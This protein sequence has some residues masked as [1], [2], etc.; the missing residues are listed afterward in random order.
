[1]S[2]I[3]PGLSVVRIISVRDSESRERVAL[4]LSGWMRDKTVDELRGYLSHLPIVI[5]RQASPELADR[6]QRELSALGAAVEL[7]PVAAAPAPAGPPNLAPPPIPTSSPRTWSDSLFPTQPPAGPGI[8]WDR[9]Q[10]IGVGFF[11]AWWDNLYQSLR[12]PNEF[13]ARMPVRGGYWEPLLYAVAT[14]LVGVLVSLLWQVPFQLL[15][16]AAS[17]GLMGKLGISIGV[18]AIAFFAF[19]ALLLL[20]VFLALG[21]F[22]GAAIGHI[23][24]KIMGGQGDYEATFRV[25]CFANSSQVFQV[26][27]GFGG[28]IATV[29]WCIQVYFGYRH[30]HRMNQTQ[31]II[32]MLLPLAL[33]VVLVMAALVVVFIWVIGSFGG[34]Q[35]LLHS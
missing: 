21:E 8:P 32:A 16:L 4:Y 22:V 7:S 14:T 27:P 12:W 24:V 33:F 34:L 35:K 30:A 26:V 17:H 18:A 6:L 10:Q 19:L 29:F 28:I 1:M 20:P 2:S 11:K 31:A 3:H 5:T 23:F 9:R 13:Y 15:P 25:L